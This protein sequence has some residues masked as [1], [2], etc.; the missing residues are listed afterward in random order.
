MMG[1]I[2]DLRVSVGGEE[3]GW[4]G[5]AKAAIDYPSLHQLPRPNWAAATIK[6]HTPRLT[7]DA[8]SN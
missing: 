5:G 3:E 2:W 7:Q 8:P 6:N 4:P 1:R